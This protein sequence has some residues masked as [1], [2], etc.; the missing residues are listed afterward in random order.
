ME[1]YLL[2]PFR[3]FVDLFER[4]EIPYVV[5]GGIAVGVQGIPRPT[6]DLDFTIGLDRAR[7]P[8]LFAAAEELGYSISG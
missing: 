3:V 5:I 4:L 6:H 7:L 1:E 8:K 2:D